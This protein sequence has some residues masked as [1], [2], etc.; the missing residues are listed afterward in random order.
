MAPQEKNNSFDVD[1]SLVP[2]ERSAG[3][4]ALRLSLRH[5]AGL[6]ESP[7]KVATSSP[8]PGGAPSWTWDF[9]PRT[10]H[11]QFHKCCFTPN[12]SRIP[13]VSIIELS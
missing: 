10:F 6:G 1:D 3:Q 7:S 12:R 2:L 5:P 9:R 13:Q 11:D 4:V 8:K